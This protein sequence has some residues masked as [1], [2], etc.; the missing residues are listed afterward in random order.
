MMQTRVLPMADSSIHNVDNVLQR[1]NALVDQTL[2]GTQVG[3]WPTNP[4][5]LGKILFDMGLEET[6]GEHTTRSTELG[7]MVAIDLY[8]VFLGLWDPGDIPFI[9]EPLGLFT[10]DEAME[11][12]ERIEDRKEV[13]MWLRPRLQLAY[14]SYFRQLRP[15]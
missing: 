2:F 6:C 9:L 12:W 5:V 14:R 10:D 7:K 3:S 15:N 11:L 4:I 13:S 8:M 1:L